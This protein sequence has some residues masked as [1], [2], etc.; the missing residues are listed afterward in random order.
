MLTELFGQGSETGLVWSAETRQE[1]CYYL[2]RAASDA[3]RDQAVMAA[4]A[5]LPRPLVLYASLKEDVA[6]GWPGSS[7]RDS[8]GWRR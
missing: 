2:H 4:V 8:T 3:E 7:P 6:P 1:P 5:L